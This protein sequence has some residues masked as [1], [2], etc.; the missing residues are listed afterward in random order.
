MVQVRP[1]D[2]RQPHLGRA[3]AARAVAAAQPGDSAS[4]D[5]VGR[6]SARRTTR[7]RR[8]SRRC[9]SVFGSTKLNSLRVG[10]TQEDVAFANPCFNGNGRD[11]TACEPT[12]AFQ[13]FT[14]QQDNTAQARVND[15]YQIERHVLLVPAEQAAATTTSSSARST[16]T[17]RP[18]TSTQDNLNGTFAFG[19]ATTPFDAAQSAD[20]S[21]SPDDPRAR[22]GPR[23]SRRRTTSSFFAQDKWK[24]TQPP[25]GDARRPLRPRDDPGAGE[26]QPGVRQRGRLSGRQG[27]HSSRA[28]GSSYALDD[29]RTVG[30]RAADTG[31]ST[32]R[33]TS[34]SS[35][36]SSTAASSR[37]RSP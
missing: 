28:S 19:R 24:M 16:S 22:P 18:T 26:E 10:W 30:R 5:H 7:I 36:A 13:T 29:G 2:E 12:L 15:A 1:A 25:D 37:T 34:R 9:S 4:V 8:S 31:G 6:R 35:A 23:R 17:S 3:L 33:R 20:L 11:Q 14:D 27:Q 32:T 21:G